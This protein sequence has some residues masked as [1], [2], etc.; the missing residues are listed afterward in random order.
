MEL[1]MPVGYPGAA[2]GGGDA[3]DGPAFFALST[4][5]QTALCAFWTAPSEFL[6]RVTHPAFVQWLAPAGIYFADPTAAGGSCAASHVLEALFLGA[7]KLD[8]V[9][10]DADEGQFGDTSITPCALA[11][12]LGTLV[13]TGLD[14]AL[15]QPLLADPGAILNILDARIVALLGSPGAPAA[16]AI[17]S[18]QLIMC[19]TGDH[20]VP[21]L[22]EPVLGIAWPERLRFSKLTGH[23][24]RLGPAGDLR[25][26]TGRFVLRAWRH[27]TDGQFQVVLQTMAEHI[28]RNPAFMS[29]PWDLAPQLVAKFAVRSSWPS[30][31]RLLHCAYPGVLE[32]AQLRFDYET[33]AESDAVQ[34]AHSAVYCTV[35]SAKNPGPSMASPPPTAAPG[36]PTGMRSSIVSNAGPHV[37]RG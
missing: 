1:R 9:I 11:A 31:L 26:L 18:D 32:D 10:A 13:G 25:A 35:L 23:D 30:Q 28:W 3:I 12:A 29:L 7:C 21:Q 22:A 16:T 2:V 24:G 17:G 15:P 36:Y 19:H 5:Q 34:N 27:N 37:K 4:A 20:E 33:Q 6:V 8:P 14:L